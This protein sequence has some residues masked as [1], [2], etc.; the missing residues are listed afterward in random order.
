MSA[1]NTVKRSHSKQCE[2]CGFS[3]DNC[4][5][6]RASSFL[7]LCQNSKRDHHKNEVVC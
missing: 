1:S 2:K 7:S 5:N 3:A 4:A 6:L